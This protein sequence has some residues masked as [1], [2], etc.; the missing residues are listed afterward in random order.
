[1]KIIYLH[2]YFK[3]PN[4]TGGTRSYDLACGFLKLGYEIEI[5]TSTSDPK[6]KTKS[7][8]IKLK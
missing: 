7:A 3:L 5:I 8:G 1:M 2:Q 4:E 6:F